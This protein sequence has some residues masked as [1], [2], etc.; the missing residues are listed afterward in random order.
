MQL[1]RLAIALC[2]AAPAV[3]VAQTPANPDPTR[4]DFSMIVEGTF[5]RE[6]AAEFLRRVED[7]VGLRDR[8]EVG[9]PPLVVTDNADEIER[10]EHQLAERIDDA[11]GSRRGQIFLPAMEGQLKRM[12][13]V[14]A[15]AATIAAIMDD[16]PGEFDIDVNETYKK[17]Y[18]LA[19]MPPNILLQLP[20]LPKDIEYRFVGRHLIL[21]DAR[22]NIVL[23]EIPYAIRC[24][25][26]VPEPEGEGDDDDDDDDG[27]AAARKR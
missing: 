7:Y 26:C 11:R 23:D 17:T 1:R 20:D 25:D 19:T 15:D 8:L 27:D 24:R 18:P 22:A 21:R 9:L 5:D 3:V 4:P 12:L 13:V 2:F 10:F 6:T 14:R 16:N